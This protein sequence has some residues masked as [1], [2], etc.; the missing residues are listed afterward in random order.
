MQGAAVILTSPCN[1]SVFWCH[2]Y[3]LQSISYLIV[4]TES[5]DGIVELIEA[6][7]TVHPLMSPSHEMFAGLATVCCSPAVIASCCP[8]L[9]SAQPSPAQ[10]L[11]NSSESLEQLSSFKLAFSGQIDV[12]LPNSNYLSAQ[13]PQHT[14]TAHMGPHILPPSTVPSPRH[15]R[16]VS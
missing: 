5:E 12:Q 1:I 4:L 2:L 9:P 8:W 16:C 6:Q 11:G 10:L 15:I 14:M 7:T 13:W 3:N